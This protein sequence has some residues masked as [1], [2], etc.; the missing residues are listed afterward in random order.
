MCKHY[1]LKFYR[2]QEFTRFKILVPKVFQGLLRTIL[3]KLK[4]ST[5]G[6]TKVGYEFMQCIWFVEL[7]HIFGHLPFSYLYY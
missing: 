1:I 7:V 3:N 6:V 5:V 2:I 4:I